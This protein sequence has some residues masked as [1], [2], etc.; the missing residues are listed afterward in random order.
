MQQHLLSSR[1]QPL[2][3]ELQQLMDQHG[4]K[5][6]SS[7]PTGLYAIRLALTK[8][9]RYT[10]DHFLNQSPQTGFSLG[11]R[12]GQLV[13][14][15]KA[16]SDSGCTFSLVDQSWADAVGWQYRP[17][18]I[19]LTLADNTSSR[20]VGITEPA[21]GLVAAGT[22]QE[23]IALIM[24]LVVKGAGETFQLAVGKE[25]LALHSAWVQQDAQVFSYLSTAGER[26][27]L[28]VQCHEGEPAAALLA[29][30]GRSKMRASELREVARVATLHFSSGQRQHGM[31]ADSSRSTSA[32]MQECFQAVQSGAAEGGSTVATQ[33]ISRPRPRR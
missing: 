22:P 30:A 26:C 14:P 15:P 10:L 6:G 29:A 19:R 32:A 12:N 9:H 1:L 31:V 3:S 2:A 7:D 17:T 33:A 27:S 24:A 8:G 18:K 4:V 25:H 13:V 5:Q 16:I 20:V 21:W 11:L 28:P 23:S